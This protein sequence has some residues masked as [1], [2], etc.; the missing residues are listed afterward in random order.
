MKM[1][2]LTS[3]SFY[4]YALALMLFIIIGCDSKIVLND[5][6][7]IDWNNMLVQLK[8]VNPEWNGT[9]ELIYNSNRRV[10]GIDLSNKTVSSSGLRAVFS[11]N[12]PVP[13]YYCPL[14]I[15]AL[16]SVCHFSSSSMSMEAAMRNNEFLFGNTLIILVR[17][18]NSLF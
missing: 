9:Y 13:F 4:L 11:V 17:F 10:I 15:Y 3:N 8:K 5:G 6:T 1:L 2:S 7:V 18:F 12:Y 16:L 14:A